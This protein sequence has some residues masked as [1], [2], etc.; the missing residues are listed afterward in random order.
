ML[1]KSCCVFLRQDSTHHTLLSIEYILSTGR[2]LIRW[3]WPGSQN[4]ILSKKEKTRRGRGE[5][6]KWGSIRGG[7]HCDVPINL[8]IMQEQLQIVGTLKSQTPVILVLILYLARSLMFSY[9]TSCALEK[10]MAEKATIR[11]LGTPLQGTR[12]PFSLLW[13]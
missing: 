10:Q 12:V 1:M 13:A 9:S 5:R 2:R 11:T 8:E 4:Q 7:E 6:K 3:D